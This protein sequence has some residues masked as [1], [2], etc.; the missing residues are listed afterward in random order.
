MVKKMRAF[1]ACECLI[2]N[3]LQAI[4]SYACNFTYAGY[5][6]WKFTRVYRWYIALQEIEEKGNIQFNGNISHSVA[7]Y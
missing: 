7:V 6:D 2:E 5:V 3:V 1:I 4:D